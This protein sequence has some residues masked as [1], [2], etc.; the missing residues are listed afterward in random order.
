VPVLWSAVLAELGLRVSI[1]VAANKLLAKL[2][3]QR[4]K[5]DGLTGMR[6]CAGPSAALPTY[7][8]WLVQKLMSD[9]PRQA[10]ANF[11]LS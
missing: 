5:P 3:S 11:V 4:G 7:A 10:A 6:T 8:S 2:A 1:G 9:T